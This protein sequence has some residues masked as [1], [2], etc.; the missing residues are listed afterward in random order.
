[1][2]VL[3]TGVNGFFGLKLAKHLSS[4]NI[5]IHGVGLNKYCQVDN[6]HYH[7][8]DI[9][10][11][12]NIDHIIEDCD[13]IYHFA[14]IT[15]HDAIV[16]NPELAKKV[17]IDSTKIL[18]DS[19]EKQKKSILFIYASSGKIYGDYDSLPILETCK[20]Q[21][22]NILGTIKRQTEEYIDSRS[23]DKDTFVILRIFNVYGPGQKESFLIPTILKQL[24]PHSI[25]NTEAII[26]L[27]NIYDKRD[28]IHIN[29]LVKLFSKF[30]P[31][32]HYEKGTNYY[33]VGSNKS[34]DPYSIVKML[35]DILKIKII[36][37]INKSKLRNDERNDEYCSNEKI[38]KLLNWSPEVN[39]EAGLKSCISYFSNEYK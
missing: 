38:S 11:P 18:L 26:Q 12:N 23:N 37:N 3:I 31:S 2:K 30:N 25:K 9:S 15:S 19:I 34:I 22:M 17:N 36:V 32:M 24:L 5:E 10:N 8:I 20:P 28:Y 29:D 27:G 16:S 6:I 7:K 14:A 1:M 33:N 35:E 13:I 21:P 39:L 4:K